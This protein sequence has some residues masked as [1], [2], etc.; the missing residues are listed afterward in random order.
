MNKVGMIFCLDLVPGNIV[1]KII[2]ECNR[3]YK[4]KLISATYPHGE[5]KDCYW[6]W[7][8][9]IDNGASNI[10]LYTSID[11]YIVDKL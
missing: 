5:S 9:V 11:D 6:I 2:K 10:K 3:V 1:G 8:I 4:Y 7:K